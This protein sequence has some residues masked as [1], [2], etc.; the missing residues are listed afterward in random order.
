MSIRIY[1]G[2]AEGVGKACKDLQD[3]QI[4]ALPTETV[5]GLAGDALRENVCR[6]IFEV[7][8][9]PLVDPLIIHFH[10]MGQLY[11]IA[12]V[13]DLLLKLANT[14]WPGALTVVL[15]KMEVVPDLVT[16]GRDT[17]A[18]RMPA[19]PLM[20]EVLE[21]SG[22]FLAAPSAN[23]FGYVSPTRASH[24][25]DS[26]HD[27]LGA[28]LDG[29]E[30]QLGLESTILDLSNP[31]QPAVLRLGPVGVGELEETIGMGI[32]RKAGVME[33]LG[34]TGGLASPGTLAKHYSPNANLRLFEYGQFPTDRMGLGS[35]RKAYVFFKRPP[36]QTLVGKGTFFW[37]SEEGELDEAA[38]NLFELLRK[39]DRLGY[40]TV[41]LEM[42]PTGGIG[43]AINDRLVRAAAIG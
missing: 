42:A 30:C 36:K 7:K 11:E 6:K 14:F 31:G 43:D 9:R 19:F 41:D 17:V 20:R 12:H 22:L 38:K 23:P 34:G 2:N 16:A 40:K 32:K 4:V 5:Y 1:P 39:L 10:D 27:R 8:M 24:V 37:L 29:G 13:P 3:G 28:V 15:K 18:V 26:L 33:E 25:V 35:Q 21:K